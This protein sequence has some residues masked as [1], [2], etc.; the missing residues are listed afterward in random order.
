[1][2][3]GCLNREAAAVRSMSTIAMLRIASVDA[4]AV[5]AVL[6]FASARSENLSVFVSGAGPVGGSHDAVPV[7]K[8]GQSRKGIRGITPLW[9]H[10]RLRNDFFI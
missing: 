8:P 3:S 6:A 1:M 7:S 2:G 10:G 4:T 5:S 9:P